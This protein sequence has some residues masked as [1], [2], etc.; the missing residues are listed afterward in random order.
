[1][2]RNDSLKEIM[3]DGID[4][5]TKEYYKLIGD[6]K[7]ESLDFPSCAC[8]L[9]KF[10]EDKIEYLILGDC[11]LFV[12]NKGIVETFKDDAIS[13]LDK[14]VYSRIRKGGNRSKL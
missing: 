8:S 5:I 9:V 2:K 11:T 12:D 7:V 4:E 6:N 14:K 13:K 10:Y 1:M 3:K